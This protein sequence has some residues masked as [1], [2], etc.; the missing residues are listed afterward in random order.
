MTLSKQ[1]EEHLGGGSVSGREQLRS[2]G[3]RRHPSQ[4]LEAG[5]QLEEPGPRP[6]S[7]PA[8]EAHRRQPSSSSPHVEVGVHREG[9]K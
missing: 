6:T 7:I 1:S 8:P 3:P 4:R 5:E 2:R 9:C